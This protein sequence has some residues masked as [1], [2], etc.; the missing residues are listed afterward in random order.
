MMNCPKCDS[1]FEHIRIRDV[2]CDRCTTCRGLW[3]DMLEKEDLLAMEGSDSIDIGKPQEL[4]SSMR[5]INCPVCQMPMIPMVDK[6]QFHI[7]YEA[8][9]NCFGTFFDAGEFRDLKD[10]TVVERLQNMVST[11]R[12]P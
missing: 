4:Y 3:F 8:C 1:P 9:G 11:L 5:H 7:Q 10:Y 6:D 2:A 12:K